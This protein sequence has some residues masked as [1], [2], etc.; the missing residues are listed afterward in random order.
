MREARDRY[1]FST[2]LR[3]DVLERLKQR[4]RRTGISSSRLAERLIDE[5]LRSEEFHGIVFRSGPAGRRAALASGPDVWEVVGD[6][7]RAEQ[8]GRD[9]IETLRA[10]TS[11]QEDQIG[12]ALVYYRAHPEEI[13]ERIRADEEAHTRVAAALGRNEAA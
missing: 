13:D 1:P 2:R 7:R 3:P 4:S 10:A 12:L 11:L 9:P 6:Y 5:G 8:A